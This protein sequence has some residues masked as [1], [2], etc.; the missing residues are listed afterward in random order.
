METRQKR[1]VFWLVAIL[2]G[3]P[4]LF[5]FA[6]NILW[7]YSWRDTTPRG[8]LTNVA[9]W[10]HPIQDLHAS[11]KPHGNS[12][13]S[14]YLLYGQPGPYLSTAVCRVNVDDAAWDVIATQLDLKPIPKADGVAL[15]SSIVSSSDATWWPATDSKS[16]YFASAR[17]LAGDEGD[18]YR[19]ARDHD[20]N[21]AYIHY[22]F[23]F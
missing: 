17:L 19:V 15:R 5:F 10:P 16:E 3:T 22:D 20:A 9:D 23:N 12:S 14:L 4:L 18:L 21:I 11:L 13:F 6:F 2:V 8:P 7:A 1:A